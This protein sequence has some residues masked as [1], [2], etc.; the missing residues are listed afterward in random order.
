MDPR[1]L[2]VYG[3]GR[4]LFGGHAAPSAVLGHGVLPGHPE[5]LCYLFVAAAKEQDP[6][7]GALGPDRCG[8]GGDGHRPEGQDRSAGGDLPC[9][10][11][12]ADHEHCGGFQPVEEG[13][14][15]ARGAGAV[16]AVRYGHWPAGGGWRV[17]AHYRG[18]LAP[19]PDLLR[20]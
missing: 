12:H 9:L 14:A 11:C 10:L 7:V 6:F 3:G 13:Q 19:Q 17:S 15:P 20:L 8:G 18:Q 1:R 16:L 4:L 2:A 5:L